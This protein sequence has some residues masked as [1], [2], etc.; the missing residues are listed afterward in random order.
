MTAVL[1]AL[2]RLLGGG[3]LLT[4][5]PLSAYGQLSSTAPAGKTVSRLGPDSAG[6]DH[7]T[8]VRS[9]WTRWAWGAPICW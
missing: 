8:R 3:V 2:A 4:A 1:A 9:S 6:A 5:V 7:P